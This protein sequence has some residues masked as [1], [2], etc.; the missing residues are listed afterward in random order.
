MAWTLGVVLLVLSS[1]TRPLLTTNAKYGLSVVPWRSSVPGPVM[2][3]GVLL[4]PPWLTAQ[5][6]VMVWLVST[7]KKRLP[8]PDA[9]IATGGTE[10]PA[11]M[12]SDVLVS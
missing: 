6:T 3:T 2:T 4:P 5:A 10:L 12:V 11:L 8:L 1:S 9:E 7:A